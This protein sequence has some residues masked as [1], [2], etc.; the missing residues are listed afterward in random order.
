MLL[1]GVGALE[2]GMIKQLKASAVEIVVELGLVRKEA[3]REG[4]A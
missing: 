4:A 2:H 3:A 1:L